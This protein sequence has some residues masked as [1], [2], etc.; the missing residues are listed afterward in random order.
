VKRPYQYR[1]YDD[2]DVLS[3]HMKDSNKTGDTSSTGID[4]VFSHSSK[5]SK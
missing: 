3:P 1:I 4:E 5:Q 2:Y